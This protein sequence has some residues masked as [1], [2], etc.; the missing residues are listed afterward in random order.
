VRAKEGRRDFDLS[1]DVHALEEVCEKIGDVSLMIIDPIVSIVQ[2]DNNSAS[3]VRRSL[4]PLISL[5]MKYNAVILGLQHFTK[6]SKGRDPAERVLGSGAWVQASR[7][8]LACAAVSE[9]DGRPTA[10]MVFTCVK[11]FYKPP[12]GFEYT[13]EEEINTEITRVR[14]GR[15]ID[16]SAHSIIAEAE[17]D[18][19]GNSKL[20][21]AKQWLRNLLEDGPV[22]YMVIGMRAMRDK[23]KSITL[24]RA[25][26]SLRVR[27]VREGKKACWALPDENEPPGPLLGI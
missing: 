24:R 19:E 7:I 22:P 27:T 1:T 18:S 4:Q 26:E 17:G 9:G 20:G 21:D 11:T 23:I 2:K 5:G 13:P 25:K 8:T 6:G 14:W 3:D 16:G 12:G 10:R 15:F